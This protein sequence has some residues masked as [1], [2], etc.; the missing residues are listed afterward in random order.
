MRPAQAV[1]TKADKTVKLPLPDL[2]AC[3]VDMTM[4]QQCSLRRNQAG[5]S[6]F[7][8]VFEAQA[9]AVCRLISGCSVQMVFPGVEDRQVAIAGGGC[10]AVHMVW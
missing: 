8:P 3:I 9:L 1:C 7:R 4:P 5:L 6:A 2:H 10:Q